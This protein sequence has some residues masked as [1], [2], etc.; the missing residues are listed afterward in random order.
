ME[1]NRLDTAMNSPAAILA[2]LLLASGIAQATIIG[3][4][5]PPPDDYRQLTEVRPLPV[6]LD[7]DFEFR[8]TKT[9][10]IGDTPLP[11]GVTRRVQT[12]RSRDPTIEFERSYRLY[13]AVTALDQRR[14]YGHYFDFFWRARQPGP[15]TVRLEYRQEKLR[16]FTQ[17]REVG[18]AS[19]QGSHRTSF[20]VVGDD[21]FSDGRVVSWRCLLLRNGRIVAE[22][23]SYL[24]R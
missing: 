3:R 15:L 21:F 10:V 16:A 2:W 17:A 20:A 14:R 8:K 6:A 18:Y 9:F 24:W 13:G 19:A 12:G 1:R 4:E 7:P 22:E 5:A 23:R 11:Q